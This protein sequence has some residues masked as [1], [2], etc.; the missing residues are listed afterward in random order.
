[1]LYS[2]QNMR[3]ASQRAVADET[4]RTADAMNEL[5]DDERRMLVA[6]ANSFRLIETR[7]R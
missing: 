3:K 4:I 6:E 5:D 1:M 2:V 7:R